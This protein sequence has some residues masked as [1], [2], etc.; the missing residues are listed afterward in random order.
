MTRWQGDLTG[1]ARGPKAWPG[2]TSSVDP[3]DPAAVGSG[4]SDVFGPSD[5]PPVSLLVLGTV[6][7][8]EYEAVIDVEEAAAARRRVFEAGTDR[9]AVEV[10]RELSADLS[11]LDRS[12]LEALE[13]LVTAEFDPAAFGED[14]E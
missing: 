14:G 3:D 8:M 5:D 2:H 11:E 4:P 12:R 10:L 6:D 9:E 13:A 7:A 1:R